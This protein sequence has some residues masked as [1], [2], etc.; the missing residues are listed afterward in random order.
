MASVEHGHYVV[1][2]LHVGGSKASDIKL[3]LQR[4]PRNG[5]TLFPVGSIL[6]NE[7]H[8]DVDV[9]ELHEET[10]LTLTHDYLTLLSDAPV[11]VALPEGQR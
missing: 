8:V 3:V 11:R 6:P 4:E 5:K 9:R 2:V 7:E 1:V 10:G